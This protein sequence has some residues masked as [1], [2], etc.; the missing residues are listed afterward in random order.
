MKTFA[1]ISALAGVVVAT[2]SSPIVQVRDIA[3]GPTIAIVGWDANQAEFG[4][5]TRL[6]RDGSHQG[7]AR[8]GE[9]RLFISTSYVEANGGFLHA[10]AH[11]GKLLRSTANT[12]TMD[13][14]PQAKILD[15]FTVFRDEH[16][17]QFGNVCS[18]VRTV[19]IGVSDEFLR[20]NRDS[21]VVTLRPKTGRKWE[22]RLDKALIDGY[23]ATMDSVS[24]D[25]KSKSGK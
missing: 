24:A 22:V 14:L 12:R 16:A 15:G 19:G 1:L 25:L 10:V 8:A 6:R 2:S 5:R 20:E 3:N 13:N 11:N 21:L 17:C 4:L 9:H 23:L 18:P 7:E